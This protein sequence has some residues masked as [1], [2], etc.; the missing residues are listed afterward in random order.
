MIRIENLSKSFTDKILLDQL[1]YHFPQNQRIALVGAN[2]QG[3]TTL[4]NILTGRETTNNGQV[5]RPK[6]MRLGYLNQSAS[7]SP[8]PT[9]R[10]ECMAGHL[11]LYTA[12]KQMAVLL[13][14]MA[15]EFREED[16]NAYE[17]LLNLYE[18]NNGYQLEGNA[19]KILLGL[20]FS[21][22]QLDQSPLILS[23]GWRMRL[24]LARCLMKP[25]DLLL[26]D[27]PTN[28][29]DL[30]MRAALTLALQDYSGALVVVSHD[31]AL[32]EATTDSFYVVGEGTVKCL[33]EI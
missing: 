13:E 33:K 2:G 1:T 7:I 10:E 6:A 30:D 32:I 11:E 21:A 16:Y 23:G 26:L 20:G 27:E 28:H 17:A 25:A 22:E 9:I 4:L 8:E 12:H 24:S 3:K 14:K 19:E 29:L 15:V 31:R 18:S 5:I